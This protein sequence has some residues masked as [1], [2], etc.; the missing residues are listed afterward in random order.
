MS[1]YQLFLNIFFIED[2]MNYI[3]HLENDMLEIK[4][5]TKVV[6]STQTQAII[7]TTDCCIN[8]TGSEIE[9]K[10]LN[11]DEGEVL[12]AGKFVN[13]KLGQPSGKKQPFLK[14]IFK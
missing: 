2:I 8:I 13:L 9:V 5:A 12:L 4:G 10:K 1:F 14:R 11:L 3:L 7:E 6:S